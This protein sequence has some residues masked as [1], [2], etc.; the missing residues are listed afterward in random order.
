MEIDNNIIC[1]VIRTLYGYT[2]SIVWFL[3]VKSEDC[4]K[5]PLGDE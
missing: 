2:N 1:F 4:V 3:I 5:Q